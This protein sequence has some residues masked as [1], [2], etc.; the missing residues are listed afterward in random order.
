MDLRLPV[1]HPLLRALPEAPGAHPLAALEHARIAAQAQ[2]GIVRPAFA[3]QDAGLLADDLHYEQ[4]IAARG[5]VA[6]RVDNAHDH[7]NA[8]I[9]LRHAALK[10]ALNARQ[11]ADIATVGT[12]Q[13][14]RGQYALTQ[15]DEAGAI[16]WLADPDLLP[17]WDAHDW[18]AL[19]LR[20]RAAWGRR[21]ALSVFGH[22]LYEHVWKG[23]ALPVAKTLVVRVDAPALAAMPVDEASLVRAWPHAEAAVAEAIRAAR[24]LLDPQELRPL[25][26]AGIPGWHAGH[27]SAAFLR[28]APCFRPLRP[29]RRYPA[30]LQ[31]CS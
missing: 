15:F 25:P 7:Y 29:G 30:P 11:L 31:F 2:D 18:P 21:I 10:Q 9:W 17:L 6:T 23:R 24:V 16:A 13:R 4:R 1:T 27:D 20:E 28:D 3:A 8:F 12:R 26:L 22:A 19:F 14:T 5:I